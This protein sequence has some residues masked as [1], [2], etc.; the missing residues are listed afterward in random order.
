MSKNYIVKNL[1]I[2]TTFTVLILGMN[3][4]YAYKFVPNAVE[5]FIKTI[6]IS[7]FEKSILSSAR[8]ISIAGKLVAK[9]NTTFFPNTKDALGLTNVQ[10]MEKGLAPIGK[11]GKPVELHH[12]KQNDN[13]MIVE[14][15]R[16]EHK[17]NTK[18]LHSY[19]KEG[20]INRVSFNKF[21]IQH[22]KERAKEF[23]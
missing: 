10:R 5:K 3:T 23:K 18:I 15:T 22:W 17:S 13:G 20:E 9:R 11:D 12:L 16:R 21:K 7:S 4:A 1:L 6:G 8:Y 2:S 19:K 14:L